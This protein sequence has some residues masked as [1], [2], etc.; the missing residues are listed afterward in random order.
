MMDIAPISNLST[1]MAEFRN[2]CEQSALEYKCGADGTFFAQ[3]AV[4]AEAPG[5]TETANHIPLSGGSGNLLWTKMRKHVGITRKD[6]YVTNVCKRQVAFGDDVRHGID[7]HE[8]A[9]WESLLLWELGHLPHIKYILVLG[10]Y[11]LSALTGHTGITQW[12][13]SV[14]TA[15]I[16]NHN[17]PPREVQVLC[18]NNPAAVLREPRLDIVFGFDIGKLKRVIDG[19]FHPTTITTEMYPSVERVEEWCSAASKTEDMVA[20]DIETINGDTACIG[21]ART[22]KEALC[23]A[24]R[25]KSEHVYTAIEERKI[26]RAINEFYNES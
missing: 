9:L 2:R 13:G 8:L 18:C 15:S 4:I 25:S 16:P 5:P 1:L 19:D 23:I 17:G 11:A 7:A 20:T 10:N 14:L 12:R 26:R 6:C 21:F 22:T 24:F 3:V